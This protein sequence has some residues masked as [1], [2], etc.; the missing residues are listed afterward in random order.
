MTID[1]VLV[2][3]HGAMMSVDDLVPTIEEG[4]QI[5][6]DAAGPGRIE[7][8]TLQRRQPRM[9]ISTAER[10]RLRFGIPVMTPP[11]LDRHRPRHRDILEKREV[12]RGIEKDPGTDNDR[13]LKEAESRERWNPWRNLERDRAATTPIVIVGRLKISDAEAKQPGLCQNGTPV[14]NSQDGW[15]AIKLRGSDKQKRKQRSERTR[16]VA[17]V[18]GHPI[19]TSWTGRTTAKLRSRR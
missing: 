19:E 4:T 14:A 11:D 2:S 10:R 7:L 12:L 13:Q 5:S 8:T 16:G 15:L 3:S 17:I 6:G 18:K 1:K 9:L